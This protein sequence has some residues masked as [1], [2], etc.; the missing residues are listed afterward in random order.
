MADVFVNLADPTTDGTSVLF[1]TVR[2]ATE[3]AVQYSPEPLDVGYALGCCITPHN[4]ASAADVTRVSSQQPVAMYP[5]PS[6]VPADATSQLIAVPGECGLP[7]RDAVPRAAVLT[8]GATAAGFE[9]WVDCLVERGGAEFNVIVV[10][11]NGMLHT[12]RELCALE[13]EATHIT[14]RL[15]NAV[16]LQQPYT[17]AMQARPPPPPPP[18]PRPKPTPLPC[19]RTISSF[20]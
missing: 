6:L 20:N 17:A 16:T 15:P 13:I 1:V 3:V 9:E 10:T 5:G 18:A 8:A 14:L 7:C 4:S 12:N 2:M 11:R 19:S